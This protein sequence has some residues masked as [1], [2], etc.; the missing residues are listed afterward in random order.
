[1]STWR[2]VLHRAATNTSSV[3][4]VQATCASEAIIEA[5][6]G[7]SLVDPSVEVVLVKPEPSPTPLTYSRPVKP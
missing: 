7:L 5:S 3:T 4:F 2:V 6:G 1:M